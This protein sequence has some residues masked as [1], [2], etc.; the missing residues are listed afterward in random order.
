MKKLLFA[1]LLT[2]SCTDETATRQTLEDEGY[3]NIRTTGYAFFGCG[4]DDAFRTGFT[5]KRGDK[6]VNGVVCCGLLKGC[7][8]RH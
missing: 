6:A 1:V 2:A 3:T 5:A 7:T 4:R 8:V